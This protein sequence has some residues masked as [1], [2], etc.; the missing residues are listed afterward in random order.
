MT[1]RACDRQVGH[2]HEPPRSVVAK[3][4]GHGTAIVS[5]VV[6]SDE[7]RR[8][9]ATLDR[10]LGSRDTHPQQFPQVARHAWGSKSPRQV[11]ALLEMGFRE[12]NGVAAPACPADSQTASQSR[13]SPIF[14]RSPARAAGA[15]PE[16]HRKAAAEPSAYRRAPSIARAAGQAGQGPRGTL[17]SSCGEATSS[18]RGPHAR[19]A[20][21]GWRVPSSPLGGSR[22][23]VQQACR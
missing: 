22:W 3:T 10:K 20:P 18:I 12:I 17:D 8:P 19:R 13:R 5:P 16:C 15:Q 23:R 4:E 2:R 6:N 7:R 21:S 1:T 11:A 9:S 14:G